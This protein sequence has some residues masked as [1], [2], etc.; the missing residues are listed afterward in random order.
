MNLPIV[1]SQSQKV[2]DGLIAIASMERHNTN[3]PERFVICDLLD[4]IR[5]D[6]MVMSLWHGIWCGELR[7]G[8]VGFDTEDDVTSDVAKEWVLSEIAITFLQEPLEQAVWLIE[9]W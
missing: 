9:L 5:D 8:G 7:G 2:K 1:I 3:S 4:D 6:I